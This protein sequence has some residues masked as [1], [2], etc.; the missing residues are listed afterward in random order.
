MRLHRSR[1]LSSEHGQAM[2]ETLFISITFFFV[3]LGV[4]QMA[5]VLNA[6]ALVR[7]AAYNAAR[8]ASVHGASDSKIQDAAR[9]SLLAIFPTHGRA[10]HV[11]GLYENYVA[12]GLTD[13]FSALTAASTKYY[14][15]PITQV[16]VK[17][18]GDPS[19]VVT[20]DDPEEGEKAII[21]V[22]VVHLY[23]LV[24][25]LVNRILFYLHKRVVGVGAYDY[26]EFATGDAD[27]TDLGFGE[28]PTLDN[29]ALRTH[30]KRLEGSLHNIEYRI[31]LVAHYTI[32]MQSDMEVGG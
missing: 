16:T 32:R 25:P 27:L 31:P 29:L 28:T 12:S 22:Q 7:Y 14:Y 1:A 23:E 11:R 19:G 20:F 26:L 10:D 9:L 18:Y 2:I 5:M 21:T 4:I 8:A 13:Q 30:R 17:N 15:Q 3:I 6:Q 24:I